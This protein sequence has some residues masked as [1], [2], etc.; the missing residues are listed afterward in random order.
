MSNLNLDYFRTALETGDPFTM[1]R[2][3]N[4]LI[5][6]HEIYDKAELRT[7]VAYSNPEEFDGLA[8]TTELYALGIEDTPGITIFEREVTEWR[9][10]EKKQTYRGQTRYIDGD[11]SCY[12]PGE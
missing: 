2:A 9:V 5:T 4:H 3:L 10:R 12:L 6:W 7:E 8:L 1:R 11:P